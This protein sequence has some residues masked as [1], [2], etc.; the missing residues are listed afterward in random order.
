[1][2]ASPLV[3]HIVPAEVVDIIAAAYEVASVVV[4]GVAQCAVV[5]ELTGQTHLWE[6]PRVPAQREAS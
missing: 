1:M 5:N 6:S 4:D 2:S 3:V